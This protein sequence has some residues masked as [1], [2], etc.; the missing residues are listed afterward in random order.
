MSMLEYAVGM[1]KLDD[2]YEQSSLVASFLSGL[3]CAGFVLDG[4]A[5]ASETFIRFVVGAFM[6]SSLSYVAK[7][8]EYKNKNQL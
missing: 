5:F 6:L 1:K 3:C 4:Y 8:W 7:P 2:I